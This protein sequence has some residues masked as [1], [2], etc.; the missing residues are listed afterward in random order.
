MVYFC[1]QVSFNFVHEPF[2]KTSTLANSKNFENL[3]LNKGKE[4]PIVNL[5]TS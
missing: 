5:D 4:V 1:L 3:L 2:T